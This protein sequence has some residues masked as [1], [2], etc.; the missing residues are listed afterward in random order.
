MNETAQNSSLP[1][2]KLSGWRGCRSP[3][4]KQPMNESKGG[5]QEGGIPF[6]CSDCKGDIW[7][8]GGEYGSPF[9]PLSAP[10]LPPSWGWVGGQWWCW[11][12]P[13]GCAQG[14][15]ICFLSLEEP[16]APSHLIPWGRGGLLN[17]QPSSFVVTHTWF[18]PLLFRAP[19]HHWI[20][21]GQRPPPPPPAVSF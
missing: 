14:V 7:G 13:C 17:Y 4:L 9:L 18:S 10:P 19:P 15:P 6:L 12:A 8:G 11:P 21:L 16:A 20:P 3:T 5:R 2:V 1:S